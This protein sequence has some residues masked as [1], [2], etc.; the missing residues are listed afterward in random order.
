[1]KERRP[2][3][4]GEL[5]RN[6]LRKAAEGT[7]VDMSRLLAAV[8]SLMAR[9]RR[10]GLEPPDD[11]LPAIAAGAWRAMPRL[12]AA[13]ALVLTLAAVALVLS[14]TGARDGAASVDAVIMNGAEGGG[15]GD[16]LLDAVVG[17][18]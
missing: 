2:D 4:T 18:D 5:A 16:L 12:A 11:R 7:A 13:T 3:D 9:A 1:M 6:T 14:R 10:A 15:T 8:P 17:E